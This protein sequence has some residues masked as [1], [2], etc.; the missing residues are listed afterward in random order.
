MLGPTP[1]DLDRLSSSIS[2]RILSISSAQL[3][4]RSLFS[5]ATINMARGQELLTC[6]SEDAGLLVLEQTRYFE[7]KHF[8]EE[9]DDS[10]AK[11][12]T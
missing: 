6:A 4:A 9:D 8:M 3:S 7:L 11:T 1:E 5:A 12:E 10:E 2:S